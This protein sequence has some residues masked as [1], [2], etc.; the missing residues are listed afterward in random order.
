G[1]EEG[2]GDGRHGGAG[3]A[4]PEPAQT[5][6]CRFGNL[7]RRPGVISASGP[8]RCRRPGI[9]PR[10]PGTRCLT[11][12]FLRRLWP[13]SVLLRALVGALVALGLATGCT[14][15]EEKERALTFR[16]EKN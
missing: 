1:D 5:R 2:G 8:L 7:R 16:V 12:T 11:V 13:R 10:L 15:L 3:A 4:G 6:L 9:L 14:T